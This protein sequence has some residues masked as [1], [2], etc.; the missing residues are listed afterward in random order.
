MR[1]LRGP[2]D[3]GKDTTWKATEEQ[4]AWERRGGI[5]RSLGASPRAPNAIRRTEASGKQG[6]EDRDRD[7]CE[8]GTGGQ[9]GRAEEG[10]LWIA[11][12]VPLRKESKT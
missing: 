10:Q 7:A 8:A 2:E 6:A 1:A 4:H 3:E 9:Q 5:A 11:A 12:E